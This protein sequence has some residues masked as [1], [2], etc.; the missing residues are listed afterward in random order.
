MY[1]VFVVTIFVDLFRFLTKRNY[2]MY[3]KKNYVVIQ[4]L[5]K[6][7]HYLYPK[8]F[9]LYRDNHALQFITRQEKLNPKH[10]KWVE[11]MQNFTFVIKNISGNA[12]KVVD[13]LSMKCLIL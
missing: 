3:D 9:I 8:E 10:E 1:S 11:F 13:A 12:K 5:K 2:S 6:W 7:R 4:A